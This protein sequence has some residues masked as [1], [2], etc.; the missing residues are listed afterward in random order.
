MHG[1][2]LR[3]IDLVQ[4]WNFSDMA[5]LLERLESGKRVGDLFDELQYA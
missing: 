1:R 3:K 2:Y 4:K 5:Y